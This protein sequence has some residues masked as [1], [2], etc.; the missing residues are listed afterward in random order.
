ME[1]ICPNC[2]SDDV[3]EFEIAQLRQTGTEQIEF[4]GAGSPKNYKCNNCD[5]QGEIK[6]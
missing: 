1:K 5:W 4:K 3:K 2:H 6:E